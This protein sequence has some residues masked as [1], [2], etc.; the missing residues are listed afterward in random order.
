MFSLSV[1]LARR[2]FRFKSIAAFPITKQQPGAKR[3]GAVMALPARNQRRLSH[4]Q[5]RVAVSML[6]GFGLIVKGHGVSVA[7]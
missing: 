3:L 7:P 5:R 6:G 4:S 1:A 2:I